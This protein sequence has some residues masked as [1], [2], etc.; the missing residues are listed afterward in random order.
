MKRLAHVAIA[1][2]SVSCSSRS[3][4]SERPATTVAPPVV[5]PPAPAAQTCAPGQVPGAVLRFEH[6]VRSPTEHE[7]GRATVDARAKFPVE[8]TLG[9]RTFRIAS[10][11]RRC[12]GDGFMHFL[13]VQLEANGLRTIGFT[14]S[15]AVYHPFAVVDDACRV[16]GKAFCG[17]MCSEPATCDARCQ[18]ARGG[19]IAAFDECSNPVMAE[20]SRTD[21]Q[22]DRVVVREYRADAATGTWE[23]I[24]LVREVVSVTPTSK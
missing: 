3:S 6:G 14:P 18:A 1:F 11:V 5:A 17:A 7:V 12:D 19:A 9:D 24:V 13:G 20:L 8:V 23:T 16:D 2:V 4:R 15:A 22:I 10:P 21:T